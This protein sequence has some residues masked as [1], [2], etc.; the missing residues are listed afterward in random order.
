MYCP[1]VK[2]IDSEMLEMDI[3]LELATFLYSTLNCSLETAYNTVGYDLKDE[4]IKREKENEN[5]LEDVF[6]PRLT[7]FTNN[8]DSLNNK[9]SKAGKPT[10]KDVTKKDK[11]LK[12]QERRGTTT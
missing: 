12:D 4:K 3:K 10:T 7:N 11:S 6:S 8:G 9:D 1:D 5:L 2:V